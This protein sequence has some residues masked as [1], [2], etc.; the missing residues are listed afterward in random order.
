MNRDPKLSKFLAAIS[1]TGK[2]P[3]EAAAQSICSFCGKKADAFKNEIS[4]EEYGISGFC[5]ECQDETFGE[6]E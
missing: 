1:P 6:D 3:E 2:S 5:Q 4:R